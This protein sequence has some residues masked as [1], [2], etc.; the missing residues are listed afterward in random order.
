[1]DLPR[2]KTTG[3]VF[4]VTKSLTNLDNLC[5]TTS[6]ANSGKCLVKFNQISCECTK[7]YTGSTCQL[8]SSPNSLTAYIGK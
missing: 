1:M 4:K 8:I 6:C 7:G 2:R 5:T 3:L